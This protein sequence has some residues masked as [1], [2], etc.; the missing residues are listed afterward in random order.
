MFG[1]LSTKIRPSAALVGALCVTLVIGTNTFAFAN[2]G[3]VA[4]QS[5]AHIAEVNNADVPV[6]PTE[7]IAN[8]EESSESDAPATAPAAP[9]PSTSE[10]VSTPAENADT[11]P[12]LTNRSPFRKAEA[13]AAN[14]LSVHMSIKADGTPD[15]DRTGDGLPDFTVDD[16]A[17]NDSSATNGIVRV[18]DTVTYTLEYRSKVGPADNFTAKVVFPKGLYIT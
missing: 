3:D 1:R 12:A 14:E 9:E 4:P 6:A 7:D 5:D 13:A 2:D 15:D 18:N 11:A 10:A 8:A 16:S 17:G